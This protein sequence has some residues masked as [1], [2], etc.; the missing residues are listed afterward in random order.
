MND[1]TTIL[2]FTYTY[3]RLLPQHKTSKECFEY[4]N[5]EVEKINDEKMFLNYVDF[6]IRTFGNELDNVCSF[7]MS[8]FDLL[9]YFTTQKECFEYIHIKQKERA[10]NPLFVNFKEF[11]K[12]T[13]GG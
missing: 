5:K 10:K 2:G 8:Y 12:Q 13:F 9:P 11:R 1:L 7:T 3:F 4:L 6:R